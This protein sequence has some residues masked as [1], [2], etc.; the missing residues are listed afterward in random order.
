MQSWASVTVPE[1]LEMAHKTN[2]TKQTEVLYIYLEWVRQFL[3]EPG[4]FMKQDKSCQMRDSKSCN[5]KWNIYKL[6]E[7]MI[8]SYEQ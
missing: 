7:R 2:K 5:P 1:G 8:H 6:L 3:K 4:K